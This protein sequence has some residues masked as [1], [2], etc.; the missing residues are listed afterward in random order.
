MKLL[1]LTLP[2]VIFYVKQDKICVL[3]THQLQY[4]HDVNH[5]VIMNKGQIQIQ[6]SYEFIRKSENDDSN[7][8]FYEKL[9]DEHLKVPIKEQETTIKVSQFNFRD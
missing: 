6:G 4:L 5:I 1:L 7:F 2:I 8:H 9:N 3:V